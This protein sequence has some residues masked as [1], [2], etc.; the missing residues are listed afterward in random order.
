MTCS[1]VPSWR[2]MATSEGNKV[3][4]TVY[5]GQPPPGGSFMPLTNDIA[6]PS[7]TTSVWTV[8]PGSNKSYIRHNGILFVL[9]LSVTVKVLQWILNDAELRLLF[10]D[11]FPQISNLKVVFVC[12]KEK[13]NTP[14]KRPVWVWAR[15]MPTYWA[16][17][18]SSNLLQ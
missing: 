2:Q 9:S 17:P 5:G 4:F 8:Y 13:K 15:R 10:K 11:N 16:V 6:F 7:I 3:I 12:Q 1:E 14:A 18:S